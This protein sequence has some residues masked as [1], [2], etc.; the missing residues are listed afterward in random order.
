[1]GDCAWRKY[2]NRLQQ[3]DS[4]AA[5]FRAIRSGAGAFPSRANAF[6][7]SCSI[8]SRSIESRS[9]D[10]AAAGV[11]QGIGHSRRSR[12][13]VRQRIGHLRHS[14]PGWSLSIKSEC[15]LSRPN[16]H[17]HRTRINARRVSRPN[18][19][20]IK[21]ERHQGRTCIKAEHA[22]TLNMQGRVTDTTM[23]R[24]RQ[25]HGHDNATDTTMPRTRQCH[26]PRQRPTEISGTVPC[27]CWYR[28]HHGHRCVTYTPRR[29]A[30]LLAPSRFVLCISYTFRP[31]IATTT[32][33]RPLTGRT[34]S[35]P[36]FPCDHIGL[37][38]MRRTGNP[39]VVSHIT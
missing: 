6:Y 11:W 26:G 1:M 9:R 5:S 27:W 21:A 10:Q 28:G 30:L 18:T 36:A 13:G 14:Q 25:C 8:K 32:V 39:T 24:T 37:D 15:V 2:S 22:S 38:Q 35:I 12:A 3:A 29:A 31:S 17:Q 4:S 7:P 34:Q 16:A 23:P 33:P 19:N 20:A